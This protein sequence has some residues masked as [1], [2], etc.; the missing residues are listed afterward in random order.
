MQMQN[1]IQETP[2]AVEH[3][4]IMMTETEGILILSAKYNYSIPGGLKNAID[5]AS[6]GEDFPLLRKRKRSETLKE[7]NHLQ[8]EV[9]DVLDAKII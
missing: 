1:S 7:M 5:R 8:V 4:C 3:F 6:R 2:V 9:E